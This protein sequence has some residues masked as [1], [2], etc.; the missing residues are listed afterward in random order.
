MH[1]MFSKLPDNNRHSEGRSERLDARKIDSG[2]PAAQRERSMH[3][4]REEFPIAKRESLGSV[5]QRGQPRSRDWMTSLAS[6][7][8]TETRP[9]HSVVNAL[10][11]NVR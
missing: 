9:A 2:V 1:R 3:H 5:S 10:R 11:L 4:F 7:L 6:A 8:R